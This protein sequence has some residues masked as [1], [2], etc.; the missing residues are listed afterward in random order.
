MLY[1][2]FGTVIEMK[3]AKKAI[4]TILRAAAIAAAAFM[5]LPLFASAESVPAGK[6]VTN[7]AEFLAMDRAGEYYL[8]NDIELTKSYSS[9]FTGTLNG[10]GKTINTTVSVFKVFD[11]TVRDL[12]ITG[13][14]KSASHAGAF[15]ASTSGM[16]AWNVTNRA[17]VSCSGAAGAGGILGGT[18]NNAKSTFVGCVN[19]GDVTA[20]SKSGASYAGGIAGFSD[21]VEMYDCVNYG[22]ITNASNAGQA[23]GMCGAAGVSA[24]END[25][26]LVRCSNF[27]DVSSKDN[28][29]G[30]IAKVGISGNVAPR[31]FTFICCENAG[32]ISGV[33]YV[34]GIA[35]YGYG[36]FCERI[37]LKWC[38]NTGT[39]SGGTSDGGFVSQ[40][41]AYCNSAYPNVT[42]CF[43]CGELKQSA[44]TVYRC[45]FGVSSAT[46][47]SAI[48]YRGNYLNGKGTDW[49]TYALDSANSVNRVSI[50]KAVELGAVEILEFTDE[51]FKNGTATMFLNRTFGY[52]IFYQDL[53][54]GGMPSVRPEAGY[55]VYDLSVEEDKFIN[56]S[57]PRLPL[58]DLGIPVDP[59]AKQEEPEPEATNEAAETEPEPA[60]EPEVTTAEETRAGCGGTV[61]FAAATAVLLFPVLLIKKD[62]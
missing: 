14:V 33:K 11:G 6:P 10:N 36:T 59:A 35:G 44:P 18:R 12:T 31:L 30:M 57:E 53:E 4:S 34:G 22:K 27:G 52:N 17:T 39:V 45:L 50:R 24:G 55:V 37:D 43:G 38:I 23:G 40:F 19:Y 2:I 62:E 7:E 9:T 5:I 3:T 13:T 1:L 21:T 54:N 41:F 25:A 29:A 26:Y 60:P 56:G 42:G 58:P 46:A 28:A 51:E 8:A 20:T 48:G 16:T 32:K 47:S 15:T 61:A 49:F